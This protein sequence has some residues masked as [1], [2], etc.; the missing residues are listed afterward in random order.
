MTLESLGESAQEKLL[1]HH[2][3]LITSRN[4]SLDSVMDRLLYL[5]GYLRANHTS[6]SV[7]RIKKLESYLISLVNLTLVRHPQL[8]KVKQ[9]LK[10]WFTGSSPFPAYFDCQFIKFQ[11]DRSS[12][13]SDPGM[14]SL[15]ISNAV[16]AVL[17]DKLC[18]SPPKIYHTANFII[19]I[20]STPE[21]KKVSYCLRGSENDENEW[22]F[23]E[24]EF[25][26]N[27]CFI[28]EELDLIIERKRK[29]L[30]RCLESSISLYQLA[31]EGH[32]T[33]HRLTE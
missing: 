16:F 33:S 19:V 24:L 28:V 15:D 32:V 26:E 30:Y 10:D 3:S 21:L 27:S 7:E 20:T 1:K 17:H 6:L 14:Y 9:D 18:M 8:Y 11:I 31:S 13:K 2:R 23:I 5:V 25:S 12:L 22:K 29:Y 4:C